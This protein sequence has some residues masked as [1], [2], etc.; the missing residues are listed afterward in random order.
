MTSVAFCT[1]NLTTP[2]GGRYW[3]APAMLLY[4]RDLYLLGGGGWLVATIYV[5]ATGLRLARF[6]VQSRSVWQG[7]NN[8]NWFSGLPSTGAAV[9]I[10]SADAAVAN[11]G[12]PPAVVPALVA[13]L[14]IAT[15]T[16]MLS[17]LRVPSLS[18]LF[19]RIHE[20][21]SKL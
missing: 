4:N 10:L 18:A 13:A 3:V 21:I 19:N 1:H 6:N 7:A 9:A 2:I 12:L 5:L 20:G 17:K 8:K 15:S 14:A 11:L 16:L